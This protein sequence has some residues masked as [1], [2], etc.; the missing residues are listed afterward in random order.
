[1]VLPVYL[2]FH[3][4]IVILRLAMVLPVYLNFHVLIVILRLAMVLPVYLNFHVLIVI[5]VWQW[6]Y[7]SILTSMY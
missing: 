7:L 3:V 1:M 5:T 2:N 4:L 6:Y